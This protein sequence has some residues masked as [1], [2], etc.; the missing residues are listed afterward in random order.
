ML[1]FFTHQQNLTPP[2]TARDEPPVANAGS[3]ITVQYPYRSLIL[4]GR[5]STDD[6]GITQ[7]RWQ[8][9]SQTYF[10]QTYQP[11]LT[12]GTYEFTLTVYDAAG[13]TGQD[14]VRVTVLGN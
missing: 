4:D 7:Y 1:L 6:K 12:P 10:G 2:F 8:H 9:G 3:D 13:Q 5:R 11:D 14:T